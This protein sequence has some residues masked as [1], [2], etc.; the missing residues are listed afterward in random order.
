MTITD[1]PLPRPARKH[2]A[3]RDAEHRGAVMPDLLGAAQAWQERAVCAEAD[4]EAF[5]PEKGFSPREAKRVCRACEVKDQR[6][7]YA[8]EH[9]GRFGVGGGL[10]ERE[11]R[12]LKRHGRL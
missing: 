4:P 11:R 3:L 5:F 8:L 2:W 10:S 6:M 7:E 1:Q 12:K 9:D